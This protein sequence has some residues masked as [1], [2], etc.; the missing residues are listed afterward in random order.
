MLLPWSAVTCLRRSNIALGQHYEPMFAYKLEPSDLVEKGSHKQNTRNFS[1]F[2]HS[3]DFCPLATN[4][5]KIKRFGSIS[6]ATF[7][8]DSTR[9]CP[10][11]STWKRPGRQKKSKTDPPRTHKIVVGG[12]LLPFDVAVAPPGS[13]QRNCRFGRSLSLWCPKTSSSWLVTRREML[14]V[15]EYHL[16]KH[17]VGVSEG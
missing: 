4:V 17:V 2:A 6:A 11:W 9:A 14:G 3:S 12:C 16:G 5:D 8:L 1:P 13:K 7:C 10:S 15:G